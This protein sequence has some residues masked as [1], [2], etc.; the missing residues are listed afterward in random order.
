MKYLSIAII[1]VALVVGLNVRRGEVSAQA[2][3]EVPFVTSPTYVT[4][5][6]VQQEVITTAPS[7]QHVW[8]PGQWERTPDNWSWTVGKW[9]Q[10]PFSNTY[11]VPGYWKH[12]GGRYVWQPAHWGVATQG[13]VVAKP[14]E[15]PPAYSEVKPEP[16]AGATTYIWQPGYWDW[17]GTWVWVPGQYIASTQPKA[18]WI[19]GEWVT[20]VDG[21]WRWSPAHWAIV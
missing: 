17:R 5:P 2:V 12:H 9:V 3:G 14:I 1:V 7:N 11:W 8:V 13:V 21:T 19:V 15:I 20:G 10:P 4:V 6:A 18:A 16:P